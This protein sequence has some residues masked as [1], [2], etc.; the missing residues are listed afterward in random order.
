MFYFKT[1]R[2][3]ERIILHCDLN[4]FFA[5]AALTQNVT[6][7]GLPLAVCGDTKKRH[8]IVLAKNEIA[9][10]Y[11]IQTAETVWSAKAKCP[12][13]ITVL[14]DFELYESLSV[15]ARAIYSQ[16]SEKVEC[17]GIDECWVDLSD[18]A[19]N[20]KRAVQV[21]NDIR[22]R[23]KREL[24]L[25]VSCGVSFSKY[26]A[27][28]G[29][30]LKKPD[31]TTCISR[32]NYKSLVWPLPCEALLMVGCKTKQALNGLGIFTVGDL[33]NAPKEALSTRLG[34]NGVKLKNAA[35]GADGE[36]VTDYKNRPLPKSVSRSATAERD[37]TTPAEVYA[38]LIGFAEKV[39]V[40][41]RQYGLL[42]GSVGV[43]VVSPAFEGAELTAPLP[44]LTNNSAILAKHAFALFKN[45]YSQSTPVRAI[46][47]RVA[48]L[49][50][51]SLVQRQ[52]SLFGEPVETERLQKIEDSMLKIR[53]KYGEQAIMRA[54]CL[55]SA[56][57][58]F[59]PGFF[60][61]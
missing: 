47:L 31:A 33:A 29:S 13:L 37:L 7:K 9:K 41:L 61:G 57:K 49:S 3:M 39:A 19:M 36:S 46:G 48:N 30:D 16:Y 17:F 15:A 27:K 25:T 43:T 35:N 54:A 50:P 8:G 52:L 55:N 14:P 22:R 26:F 51:E 56:A 20:F 12:E 18:P 59:S 58:A 24:R 40:Q 10:A 6:L 4:N 38:A 45:G 2:K 28:L 11:G 32:E 42:A 23:M 5:S 53:E 21:A 60:K 1:V 44:E 34:V